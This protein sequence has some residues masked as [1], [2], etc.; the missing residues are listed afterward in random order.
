[1][2]LYVEDTSHL[3]V[4]PD[5]FLHVNIHMDS[6]TPTSIGCRPTTPHAELKIINYNN[7]DITQELPDNLMDFSPQSGLWVLKGKLHFHT[8]L[9]KCILKLNGK[10]QTQLLYLNLLGAHEVTLPSP[11]YVDDIIL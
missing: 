11:R 8:G 3:F 9:F 4:K 2:F 10:E 5:H 1:V 7:I 6:I